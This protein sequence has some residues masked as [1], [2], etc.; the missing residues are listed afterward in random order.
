MRIQTVHPEGEA[1]EP[2]FDRST[3]VTGLEQA[4]G[5]RFAPDSAEAAFIKACIRTP[6]AAGAMADEYISGKEGGK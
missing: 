2:T 5:L 1:D 3:G 4:I 6:A